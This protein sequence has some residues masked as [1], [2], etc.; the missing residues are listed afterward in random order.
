MTTINAQ[1]NEKI[2]SK[3]K[4]LFFT[5]RNDILYKLLP[6]IINW[7]KKKLS[8]YRISRNVSEYFKNEYQI[9]YPVMHIYQ[10]LLRW[11]NKGFFDEKLPENYGSFKKV[12]NNSSNFS[13]KEESLGIID[14]K[15]ET[16]NNYADVKREVGAI[17]LYGGHDFCH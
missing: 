17:D 12:L 1:K 10:R 6:Q 5:K 3:E 4:E 8:I 9:T 11:K 2:I 16:E 13:K 7:Y 15:D 14:D